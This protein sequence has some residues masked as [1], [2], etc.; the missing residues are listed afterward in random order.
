[1]S[2][3]SRDIYPASASV[4]YRYERRLPK[5]FFRSLTFV[6]EEDDD[7]SSNY[8]VDL[9]DEDTRASD[10]RAD[11]SPYDLHSLALS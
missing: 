3:E 6:T 4:R 1:M 2:R 5:C 7:T 10:D 8:G 9:A 11:K